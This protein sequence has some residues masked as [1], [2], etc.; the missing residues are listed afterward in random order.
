M[1]AKRVLSYSLILITSVLVFACCSFYIPLK[2]TAPLLMHSSDNKS[3]T[4][5]PVENAETYEIFVNNELYKTIEQSETSIAFLYGDEFLNDGLYIVKVRAIGDGKKYTTSSLSNEITVVIG[6]QTDVDDTPI[7]QFNIVSQSSKAPQNLNIVN[8]TLSWQMMDVEYYIVGIFNNEDGVSY[9]TLT[10]NYINLNDY[11]SGNEVLYIRVGSVYQNDTNLYFSD[12]T[13]YSPLNKNTFSQKYFIFDGGVYDYYIEDYQELEA[14][15]YYAFIYRL[16]DYTF[17]V[18]DSFATEFETKYYN[19]DIIIDCFMETYGYSNIPRIY[20][21]TETHSLVSGLSESGYRVTCS[22]FDGQTEPTMIGNKSA[23][24]PYRTQNTTYTAYYDFVD[25][26]EKEAGYVYASDQ[27]FLYTTVST[28]EELF[29]AVQSGVTPRFES[30]TCRAYKIYDKA[31]DAL[32]VIIEDGMTD[33]E[34]VVSIFDWISLNTTYD[35]NAY[36]ECSSSDVNPMQYACYYLEGVFLDEQGLSVCDGF[37]KA[38]SLMCNMEGVDCARISGLASSGY[39]YG[40]H[41]WNKV[42]LGNSWYMVDITWGEQFDDSTKIEQVSHYYFLIDHRDFEDSHIE[43]G[44]DSVRCDVYDTY[45]D[46]GYYSYYKNTKFKYNNVVYD[47]FIENDVELNAFLNY[48]GENQVYGID[49]MFNTNYISSSEKLSECLLAQKPTYQTLGMSYTGSVF[50]YAYTQV[51]STRSLKYGLIV[52][53]EIGYMIKN[54]TTLNDWAKMIVDNEVDSC[55]V[56]SLCIDSEFLQS[57]TTY[58]SSLSLIENFEKAFNE[59][60]YFKSANKI[61]ELTLLKENLSSDYN[62]TSGLITIN[63]NQYSV[64]IV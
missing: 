7:S 49:V 28:S 27:N 30:T 51:G 2:L 60:T 46:G 52:N 31:K 53:F 57:L 48:C 34:K 15:Y 56:V 24:T 23:S 43:G 20:K 10:T 33:Y 40:G 63:Y 14:L 1:K 16:E 55:D 6:E 11:L 25:Y 35:Y 29:W 41:A 4:W 8:G 44:F 21:L 17:L 18:A 59:N 12:S 39:N 45:T 32:D 22:F 64:K 61:I 62:S 37:S 58:D 26:E 47:L 5:T 50:P 54:N 38:F 36:I 3:I 9:Y 13:Y 42:K 19:S